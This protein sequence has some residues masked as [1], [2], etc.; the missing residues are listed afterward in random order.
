MTKAD[1]IN[2]IAMTTGVQKR[3][4]AVVVESFMETIKNSLLE[5]K[6]NVYLRGFGSFVI[7]HRA[8]KTARNIL[9]NTTMMIE[10][11]DLPSFKPSKSFVE[12]MKK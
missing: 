8:A 5:K 12:Q 7:K 11:H 9:K 3:D 2:E 10:A 4:V 6:E 1:I